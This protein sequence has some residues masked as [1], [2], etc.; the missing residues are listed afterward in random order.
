[1][2]I[3]TQS[4]TVSKKAKNVENQ[5]KVYRSKGRTIFIVKFRPPKI[6]YDVKKYFFTLCQSFL[7]R[8]FIDKFY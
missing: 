8:P 2:F 4:A 5:G 7:F 6:T 3:P 1:M